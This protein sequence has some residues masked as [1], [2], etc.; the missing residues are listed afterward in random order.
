[1]ARDID[2]SKSSFS[3]EE[4]EYIAQRPWLADEAALQ[5]NT[6][7]AELLDERAYK[8]QSGE[9]QPEFVDVAEEGNPPAD[10]P[11]DLEDD[12]D[13]ESEWSYKDLQTEAKGRELPASGSREE[14]V[15]RL[16]E[17]DAANAT[18]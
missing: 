6:K 18:A 12:Y 5:G 9:Q 10:A 7:I 2:L 15:A 13:D 11:A 8:L 1:M 16:R 14:I 3:K 17:N 4:I